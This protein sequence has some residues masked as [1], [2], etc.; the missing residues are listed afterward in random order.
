MRIETISGIIDAYVSSDMVKIRMQ[1]PRDIRL[2]L[3]IF[4]N[5]HFIRLGVPHT[6]IILDDIEGVNV[7]E[8]GRKI[9]FDKFFKGGTN[10]NF[11]CVLSKNRFKIRTY[12]RGV[13]DETASCGTGTA[14][15]AYILNLLKK[16]AFPTIVEAKSK[17]LLTVSLEDNRLYLE[18]GV[19]EIR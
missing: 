13:E 12:E 7:R 19:R 17:E 6:V 2:N 5:S 8:I 11:V 4:E 15:S 10:V 9:R 14:A 3:P 18:G 1:E 16:T